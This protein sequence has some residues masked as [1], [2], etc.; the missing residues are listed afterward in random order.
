M[1][2]LSARCFCLLH[3]TVPFYDAASNAVFMGTD[4]PFIFLYT[5][6]LQVPILIARNRRY[7]S[8]EQNDLFKNFE[9]L[10]M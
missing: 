9:I 2:P 4:N 3:V 5:R 1:V 8:K 10:P 6:A 7:I